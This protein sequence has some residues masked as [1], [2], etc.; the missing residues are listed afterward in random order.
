MPAF[1]ELRRRGVIP[2]AALALAAYYFFL[3]VPLGRKAAYFDAPLQKA[4]KKLAVAADQTNA[5]A[6]DFR[7][8]TNQLS[9]TKQALAELTKDSPWAWAWRA[10]VPLNW[11][12]D[13]IS[14]WIS[15][16]CSLPRN[17]RWQWS[18]HVPR[19]SVFSC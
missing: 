4:W 12:S 7:Q 14:D 16:V 6:I 18:R 5:A 11:L 8:I 15:P 3:F 10:S 1:R 19:L 13:R 2:G 9:E 17:R